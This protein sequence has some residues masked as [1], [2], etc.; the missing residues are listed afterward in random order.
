MAVFQALASATNFFDWIVEEFEPA[1][2][3][4]ILEVGAGIGTVCQRLARLL[5]DLYRCSQSNPHPTRSR[6]S[7]AIGG[8]AF[9][10]RSQAD[11]V[12]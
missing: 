11:N 12:R 5:R 3:E 9:E 10:N 7:Q 2:G 1:L 8:R 4:D 6:K